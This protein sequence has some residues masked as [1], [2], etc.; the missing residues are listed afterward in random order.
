MLHECLSGWTIKLNLKL[1]HDADIIVTWCKYHFYT[2][3]HHSNNMH[4][5]LYQDEHIKHNANVAATQ[6]RSH[7]NMMSI[8]GLLFFWDVTSHHWV[9]GTWRCDIT[10]LGNWYLICDVTSLGTWHLMMWHHITGYLVPIVLRQSDGLIF[11]GQ[12]QENK[13]LS[14][15]LS[16]IT[17]KQAYIPAENPQ[18]PCCENTKHARQTYH[19]NMR[20]ISFVSPINFKNIQLLIKTKRKCY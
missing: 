12:I 17:V 1:Y 20:Q 15:C 11:W 19:C 7:C 3:R 16:P 13:T 8:W 10:S 18:L 2:I 5:P 9:L 14:V 6:G 4:I